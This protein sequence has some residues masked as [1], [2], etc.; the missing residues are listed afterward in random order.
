MHYRRCEFYFTEDCDCN[1][2]FMR[3]PYSIMNLTVKGSVAGLGIISD[4]IFAYCSCPPELEQSV[5]CNILLC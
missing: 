3:I 1:E 5:G 4:A 2:V